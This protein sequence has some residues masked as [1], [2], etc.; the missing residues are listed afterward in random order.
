MTEMQKLILCQPQ[1]SG[2]EFWDKGTELDV[3]KIRIR[4]R[5]FINF[6]EGDFVHL[7]LS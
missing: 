1:S 5:G 2:F 3:S 4:I 7:I 6:H